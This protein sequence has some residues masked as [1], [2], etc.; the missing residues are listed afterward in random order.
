MNPT[1]SLDPNTSLN[2]IAAPETPNIFVRTYQALRMPTL[3]ETLIVGAVAVL[4]AGLY[5][6]IT[7]ETPD[8]A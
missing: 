8:P 4:G 2:G 3:T 6:A 7:G 5:F 1:T